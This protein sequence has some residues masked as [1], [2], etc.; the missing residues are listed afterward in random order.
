[1]TWIRGSG[2]IIS[3][4]GIVKFHEVGRYNKSSPESGKPKRHRHDSRVSR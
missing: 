2:P 3:M 4:H 1:M